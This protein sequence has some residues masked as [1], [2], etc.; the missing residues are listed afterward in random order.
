MVIL[1]VLTI[2]WTY[3][4]A[5]SAVRYRPLPDLL[6]LQSYLMQF[7]PSSKSEKDDD[8]VLTLGL[9]M[10]AAASQQQFDWSVV[11]KG[12]AK[13]R[14]Q[15][16]RQQR[17]MTSPS[18]KKKNNNHSLPLLDYQ[19]TF[20][21]LF[22][23]LQAHGDDEFTDNNREE[24]EKQVSNHKEENKTATSPANFISTEGHADQKS[25]SEEVSSTNT[26]TA[27][28][29]VNT[30]TTNNNNN[31]QQQLAQVSLHR[32]PSHIRDGNLNA[33]FKAYA[34]QNNKN[35]TQVQQRIRA[36]RQ[37][38]RAEREAHIQ[39]VLANHPECSGKEIF[40]RIVL[41]APDSKQK[42]ANIQQLCNQLPTQEEVAARHGSR[43]IIVGM[44]TCPTYRAMLVAANSNNNQGEPPV[45]AMPR[46][47]GLYH[48]G[49]NA[50]ART[51]EN[52]F[53][54]L[55]SFK[56]AP[57][58]SPYEVPVRAW[59]QKN[60]MT[61]NTVGQSHTHMVL[62]SVIFCHRTRHD[63]Y[64]GANTFLPNA[65]GSPTF[66]FRVIRRTGNSYY[67]LS[68]CVIPFT[69]CKAWYVQRRNVV[70]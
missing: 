27:E 53:K 61:L 59:V 65:T 66:S 40:L 24:E 58:F 47:A 5:L 11:S 18:G 48:T 25:V 51:M 46:V 15:H 26:S 64:S 16:M 7:A 13:A 44:D 43:A 34:D 29:K 70:W 49:T 31:N 36:Q 8:K 10:A 67:R 56:N 28:S 12:V 63:P 17:Y 39:Q 33:V 42:K 2:I 54:L 20:D 4:T 3:L 45:D 55:P 22:K 69:G 52:N 32:R 37:Q 14:D 35:L 23:F 62:I 30:A 50:L 38:K 41:S 21:R 1:T 60:R 6:L 57:Y 9:D 19:E 68:L